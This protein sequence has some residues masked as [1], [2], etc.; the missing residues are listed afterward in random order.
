MAEGDS[1]D[2]A[3]TRRI[4]IRGPLR[5]HNDTPYRWPTPVRP[6]SRPGVGRPQGVFGIFQHCPPDHGIRP[7]N[8]PE[9]DLVEYGPV[10]AMIRQTLSGYSN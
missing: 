3:D 9:F 10:D 1:H 6:V 7:K 4:V 8:E 5:G 2:Q